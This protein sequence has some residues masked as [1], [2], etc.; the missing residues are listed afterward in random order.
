MTG[1]WLFMIFIGVT[2]TCYGWLSLREEERRH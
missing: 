1:F 2:M